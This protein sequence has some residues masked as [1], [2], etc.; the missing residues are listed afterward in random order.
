MA[1]RRGKQ[2]SRRCC[3]FSDRLDRW[4]P[5]SD[6]DWRL[7][8]ASDPGAGFGGGIVPGY[9]FAPL[10]RAPSRRSDIST[11]QPGKRPRWGL[12]LSSSSDEVVN[13]PLNARGFAARGGL[14]LHTMGSRC[15]KRAPDAVYFSLHLLLAQR[16]RSL[17]NSRRASPTPPSRATGQNQS[18]VMSPDS[19][20][21]S[22]PRTWTVGWGIRFTGA[23]RMD[24]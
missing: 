4:R 12:W 10:I 8:V 6:V 19:N 15:P 13:M 23:C 20:R 21:Y 5:A 9:L 16:V 11:P 2:I 1:D 24:S 7:A 18:K 17:R 22:M 3:L 14:R